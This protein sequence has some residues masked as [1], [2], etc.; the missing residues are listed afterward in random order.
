MIGFGQGWENKFGTGIPNWGNAIQQTIDGGF[1]VTGYSEISNNRDVSLIKIDINGIE[2]WSGLYGGFELDYGNSVDQTADGGYI[3]AGR[4]TY[5]MPNSEIYLIK[6]D[7]NGVEQWNQTFTDGVGF[8]VQQTI[9]GGYIIC[10]SGGLLKTDGNG[11]EQ[12]RK[13]YIDNSFKSFQQ[14][15]DGGYIITGFRFGNGDWDVSLI[16]TDGNGIEQWAKTFGGSGYDVGNSVQQ[17]ADG[18]YIIT[19]NIGPL[20]N[21]DIFLLKTNGNGDSLWTKTFWGS[22]NDEGNSVKQTTDG[23]YII[24][25]STEF[26]ANAYL[27]K[28]DH[29]GVE[30]WN[31]RFGDTSVTT[32]GQDVIENNGGGYTICGSYMYDTCK[33]YVINTDSYG[34]VTS[35]LN[36]PIPN[37]HRK[38]KNKVD[39]SG[40]ETKGKTNQPLF[41][42]YDDGTVEKRIVIE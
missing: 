17:T 33:V 5:N 8:S 12:W 19:G 6:T 9:D 7:A 1:I 3:I 27:L 10:N 28:T 39:L 38:L 41:Y 42:L 25:G 20:D 23:G 15:A 31:R 36:I 4:Y 2:E 21:W 40:R 24:T 18:G 30:L 29:N 26:N 34:N 35:T 22:G 13:T 37:A 16:K 11:T 32:T 14:T